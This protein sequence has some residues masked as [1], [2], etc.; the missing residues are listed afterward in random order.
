MARILKT[1]I[2][3]SIAPF[4]PTKDY[5]VSFLYEDNQITK[6][7]AVIY[8]VETYKKIY[9]S[10][11]VRMSLLHNIPA[12]TL[13][14]GGKYAIEIQV[15][16]SNGDSSNFSEQRIFYCL[17][18]PI[19]K[20]NNINNV[21]KTSNLSLSV[22]YSQAKG[23]NIKNFQFL[24]YDS[25]YT[26]INSSPIFYSLTNNEYTFGSLDNTTT[27]YVKAVGETENGILLDTGYIKFITD[28]SVLP[29]NTVFTLENNY[30]DG[31]ISIVSNIKDIKYLAQGC[32]ISDGVLTIENGY[33]DYNEGFEFSADMYFC[34][35]IKQIPLGVFFK[36]NDNNIVMSLIKICDLYYLEL[37]VDNYVLYKEVNASLVNNN[38]YS[39]VENG[40]SAYVEILR[41]NNIYDIRI[42]EG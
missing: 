18:D 12:N 15:F 13:K 19:F 10:E 37:K 32:T 42:K 40:K 6:N 14:D 39:L 2:I 31:Y 34:L 30:N 36:A 22:S 21:I 5:M 3:N 35:S 17:T 33:L 25:T 1:P 24:L 29:G 16:D 26:L 27:Y 23:E 38:Q 7:R 28:Y 11:Q 41:K 4:N 8:D 20:I 9:D